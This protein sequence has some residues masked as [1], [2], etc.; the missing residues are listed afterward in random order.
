MTNHQPEGLFFLTYLTIGV[1]IVIIFGLFAYKGYKESTGGEK[2]DQ[3]RDVDSKPVNGDGPVNESTHPMEF[4]SMGSRSVAALIDL[5]LVYLLIIP[6]NAIETATS[7]GNQLLQVL[8]VIA[9]IL[10]F[11]FMEAEYGYTI[12]KKLTNIR[13]LEEQGDQIGWKT[14]TIRNIVR[15]VDFLPTLY[16]IGYFVAHYT[17]NR[18]RLGDLAANTVVVVKPDSE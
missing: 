9:F 18:Q 12:G 11:I 13:V 3:E 2:A 15:P 6:A 17:D 4:A 1:I 10:Y 8:L 14:A 16:F 5:V 7:I